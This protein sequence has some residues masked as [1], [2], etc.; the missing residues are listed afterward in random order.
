MKISNLLC[1]VM[2]LMAFHFSGNA[3]ESS[4]PSKPAPAPRPFIIHT[5][6]I[7]MAGGLKR[8]NL[9]SL[10]KIWEQRVMAPNPYFVNSKIVTHWWGHDSRQVLFMYELKSWDDIPKAFEE[11]GKIL[12]AHKGWASEDDVKAFRELW[13]SVFLPEHHS[14]EI[15]RVVGE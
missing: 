13:R 4:Q 11:R 1:L 2:L 15:Y 8:V 6:Y 12:K 10:L 9:D 14:D 7:N 5:N 3:Q